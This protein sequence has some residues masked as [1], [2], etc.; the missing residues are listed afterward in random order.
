MTVRNTQQTKRQYDM[1][2]KESAGA[3]SIYSVGRV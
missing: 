2:S 3:V 1:F